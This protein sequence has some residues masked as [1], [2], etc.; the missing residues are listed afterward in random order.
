MFKTDTNE[1]KYFLKRIREKGVSRLA[2]YQT[3]T[4]TRVLSE[5][6]AAYKSYGR[7]RDGEKGERVELKFH[8]L[9]LA[10][11]KNEKLIT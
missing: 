2:I 5:T 3:A 8:R 9:T 7:S 1:N 6:G 4:E 10:K 11:T